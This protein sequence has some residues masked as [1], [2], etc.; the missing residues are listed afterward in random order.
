MIHMAYMWEMWDVTP[1]TYIYIHVKSSAVFCL[2]R[3]RKRTRLAR[4]EI[5]EVTNKSQP[6][7]SRWDEVDSQLQIKTSPWQPWY[8]I[9]WYQNCSS[10]DGVE[11][12]EGISPRKCAQHS[13]LNR[14][15]LASQ[16]QNRCL[17]LVIWYPHI[18]VQLKTKASTNTVSSF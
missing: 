16:C 9:V 17:D 11:L 8:I 3:I 4:L 10:S 13:C 12:Y 1:V 7:S 5:H 14:A 18:F 2:G 15:R 6:V